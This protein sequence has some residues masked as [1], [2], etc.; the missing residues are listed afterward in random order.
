MSVGELYYGAY[1]DNW[2]VGKITSLENAIKNYVI[3]PYDYLVCQHWA[4][5][6]R[7]KEMKGLAMSH[8]DL[9]VAAAARR[10]GCP[11]ATNNG[12]HFQGIDGLVVISPTL[13]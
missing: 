9:W 13:I 3:L 4:D 11:L 1:K 12:V 6:R 10:H 5:I 2:G 7:Q 8:S